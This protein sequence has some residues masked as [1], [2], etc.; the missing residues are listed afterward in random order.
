MNNEE[1]QKKGYTA[2]AMKVVE[3][4]HKEQLLQDSCQDANCWNG[5]AN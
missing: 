2:P 4:Q 3:L 1:V 5:E